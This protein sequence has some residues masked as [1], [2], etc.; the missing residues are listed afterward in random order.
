MMID[1]VLADVEQMTPV[2]TK[3]HEEEKYTANK[4]GEKEGKKKEA[5]H[6]KQEIVLKTAVVTNL[7]V[8]ATESNRGPCHTICHRLPTLVDSGVKV[9]SLSTAAVEPSL[10]QQVNDNQTKLPGFAG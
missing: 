2:R 10:R 9:S 7:P 6:K 3:Q 5:R 4:D 8:S 1:G